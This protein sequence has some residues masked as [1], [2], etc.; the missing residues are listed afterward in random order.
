[1]LLSG[2]SDACFMTV[3]KDKE[4]EIMSLVL[5]MWSITNIEK[6]YLRIILQHVKGATL[7]NHL[8][9]STYKTQRKTYFDPN[10]VLL[11]RITSCLSLNPLC[12][13]LFYNWNSYC[14]SRK[15]VLV[16]RYLSTGPLSRGDGI[17]VQCVFKPA[18]IIW[19]CIIAVISWI[20]TA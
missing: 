7:L 19:W 16:S 13:V 10:N 11:F 18:T 2:A 3:I 12:I 20:S 15:S 14:C 9:S 5:C 4:W 8:N 6:F 1:M 17:G